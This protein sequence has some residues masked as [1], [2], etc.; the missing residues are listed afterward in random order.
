M[1]R[2]ILLLCAAWG[3][4]G[5]M[6][7]FSQ[8]P[9]PANEL[10]VLLAPLAGPA[11]DTSTALEAELRGLAVDPL[12]QGLGL[13]WAEPAADLAGHADA[14]ALADDDGAVVAVWGQTDGATVELH[15]SISVAAA[16]R[17]LPLDEAVPLT[18]LLFVETIDFSLKDAGE[19]RYAARTLRALLATLGNDLDAAVPAW[20]GLDLLA[21]AFRPAVD[22]TSRAAITAYTATADLGLLLRA[23]D[24]EAEALRLLDRLEEAVDLLSDARATYTARAH[25]AAYAALQNNIGLAQRLLAEQ[26]LGMFPLSDVDRA[27]SAAENALN[28]AE[29][30]VP[31]NTLAAAR[32]ARNQG[33]VA[34]FRASF[35]GEMVPDMRAAAR[36]YEAAAA[37]L[38]AEDHPADYGQI[39]LLYGVTLTN[40]FFLEV[41]DEET[42]QA[43]IAAYQAALTVFTLEAS[44]RA[45]ASTQS[46]LGD[47][48]ALLI[49][50]DDD[51]IFYAASAYQAA[52]EATD[53]RA[54]PGRYAGY[55]FN[56]GRM[57][58][59]IGVLADDT[60]LLR[61]ARAQIRGVAR[62]Y[63][64]A[65]A[66]IEFAQAQNW[67]GDIGIAIA[68]SEGTTAPLEDA[69]DALSA[70]LDALSGDLD[71]PSFTLQAAELN[72][73]LGRAYGLLAE[74]EAALRNLTRAL[75][76]FQEALDIYEEFGLYSES[77]WTEIEIGQTYYA[78]FAER[79]EEGVL[80]NAVA[81]LT[82][83]LEFPPNDPISEGDARRTLGDALLRLEE[84][85]AACAAWRVA[86]ANYRAG[87][88]RG[89]SVDLNA[90]IAEQ[91][92]GPELPDLGTRRGSARSGNQRGSIGFNDSAF[93]TYSGVAGEVITIRVEADQPSNNI[94]DRT[95]TL[96]TMLRVYAPDGSLLAEE[97]DIVNGNITDSE[98]VDL[99]LPYTGVY[100][101]QVGSYNGETRGSFTL[102][103]ETQAGT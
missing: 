73:S 11:N 79:P 40:L 99:V 76:A 10:M 88:A 43:S 38:T 60:G 92:A 49:S 62:H 66:P 103:L 82:S 24:T 12:L 37:L 91:C 89:L 25:P 44:P 65:T 42:V 81:S 16:A 23:L 102:I 5:L 56:L 70:G 46:G 51:A 86:S 100:Y 17:H 59:T 22:D 96:D 85:E 34:Q 97:D 1:K 72:I 90:Y 41:S 39:N 74:S 68:R 63:T 55:Q 93:W 50:S 6:P 94:G 7:V 67:I 80:R 95:G 3:I 26:R 20:Q 101:I 18:P 13:A 33:D 47:A 30:A 83:G 98:L 27:L 57:L 84:P 45:F 78:L 9:T 54:E 48:Y 36:A 69:I 29:R 52:L 87:G 8:T 21:K 14:I 2:L 58:A 31:P 15:Y 64:A 71:R 53:R 32:I 28:D 4:G 61:E 77:R 35:T 75:S 19:A